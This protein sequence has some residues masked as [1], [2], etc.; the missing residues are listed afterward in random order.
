[1]SDDAPHVLVV[2]D[3]DRLRDLLVRF[4]GQ[5]GFRV[6]AAADAGD[7]RAK[8]SGLVFDLL[9]VDVMMPGQSG[10]DFVAELRRTNAV[11]VLMLTAM[12]EPA[13]RIKGLERGADDYLSKPFEP[14]ELLLRL[15]AILRRATAAPPPVAGRVV[16]FGEFAFDTVRGELRQGDKVVY[17]TTGE[18]QLLRVLARNPGVTVSR[19]ALAEQTGGGEG[20]AVDVQITRLRRKLERDPK[21]PRHLTTV[22]GAGY[23]LWAD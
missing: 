23:V 15:N 3:D 9:V 5:N 10:L 4:L 1:M 8:L 11:P 16:K 12:G 14:R 2:D 18:Q 22:W 13:D 7:A 21:N 20:R 17:L 19:T 6:S